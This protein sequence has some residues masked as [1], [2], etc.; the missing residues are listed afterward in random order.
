[1]STQYPRSTYCHVSQIAK[2]TAYNHWGPFSALSNFEAEP[3][4]CEGCACTRVL[5]SPAY[6][7]SM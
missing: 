7:S 5:L 4:E 1:M 2:Y 3:D 6:E